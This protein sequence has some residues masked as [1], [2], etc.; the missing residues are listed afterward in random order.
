MQGQWLFGKRAARLSANRMPSVYLQLV[1]R[2]VS[3][4]A[5]PFAGAE[6][7][8]AYSHE[9]DA[10]YNPDDARAEAALAA[11][12]ADSP[13]GGLSKSRKRVSTKQFIIENRLCHSI[14]DRMTKPAFYGRM[15]IS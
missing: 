13:D 10:D 4:F 15:P 3:A 8:A 14:R 6:Y 11:Y 5:G 9:L 12:A 7:A 2:K 1:L